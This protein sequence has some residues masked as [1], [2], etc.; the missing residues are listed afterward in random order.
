MLKG[1]Q[2][3]LAIR[4]RERDFA[5]LDACSTCILVLPA[6]NSAH[7]ELGYANC[8]GKNVAVYGKAKPDLI[9][10]AV[11]LLTDNILELLEWLKQIDVFTNDR[12]RERI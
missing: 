5:A 9:Y 4:A 10:G 6:G 11:D 12:K 1:L 2:H 3:P 7:F 8:Q